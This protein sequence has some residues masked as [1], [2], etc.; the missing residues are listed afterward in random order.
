MQIYILGETVK[1][2]AFKVVQWG[3]GEEAR[4]IPLYVTSVPA[5]LLAEKAEIA[6]RTK[7]RRK[8][9][10]RELSP[11]RLGKGVLG[12]TGYLLNQMGIFPTSILV[13]IRKS[14][15]EIKFE[16]IVTNIK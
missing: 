2:N 8:G 14:D 7:D 9:Y 11:K 15:G 4:K 16:K 3:K 5:G 12:V 13:N 6:R 10:Q 1:L